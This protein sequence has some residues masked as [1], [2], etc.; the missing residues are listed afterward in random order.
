MVPPN[1]DCGRTKTELTPFQ[2]WLRFDCNRRRREH[3]ERKRLH[4]RPPMRPSD[5]G[6]TEAEIERE[7]ERLTTA[8]W[9]HGEIARV[10]VDTLT[11]R[12]P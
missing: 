5:F 11:A 12:S 8:G 2:R 10:L 3:T 4:P 6:L 1:D 7:W 9:S